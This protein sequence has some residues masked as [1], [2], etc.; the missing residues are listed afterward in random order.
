MSSPTLNENKILFTEPDLLQSSGESY[1]GEIQTKSNSNFIDVALS[2]A[3]SWSFKEVNGDR[4]S[5]RY[6]SRHNL[7]LLLITLSSKHLKGI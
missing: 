5:P 4:Y 2:Y 6:D 3:L 7:N 1:G